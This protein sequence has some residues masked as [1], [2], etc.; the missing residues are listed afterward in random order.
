MA[1]E[2]ALAAE[3]HAKEHRSPPESFSFVGCYW[4][5]REAVI[6]GAAVGVGVGVGVGVAV[7][8]GV[9]KPDQTT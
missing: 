6:Y 8:V 7:G 9:T 4:P 1:F 2:D 5:H 3:T